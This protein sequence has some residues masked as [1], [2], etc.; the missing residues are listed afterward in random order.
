MRL[1][2]GGSPR[3]PGA[4]DGPAGGVVSHIAAQRQAAQPQEPLQVPP[5]SSGIPV[6]DAGQIGDRAAG[7]TGEGLDERP[8]L[9]GG[10]GRAPRVRLPG[11][12]PASAL[13]RC[14]ASRASSRQSLPSRCAS[15]MTPIKLGVP[16]VRAGMSSRTRAPRALRSGTIKVSNIIRFPALSSILTTRGS[17]QSRATTSGRRSAGHRR[18]V[19]AATKWDSEA[20]GCSTSQAT[21]SLW[22]RCQRE[23]T[24]LGDRPR[25]SAAPAQLIRGAIWSR[26]SNWMS[27]SSIHPA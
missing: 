4:G 9:V 25:T 21:P 13:A 22:S 8:L 20:L 11:R 14:T 16:P 12:I 10:N 1:F 23:A 17:W 18:S 6:D 26:L 7:G 24:A 5:H 27:S 3:K 15:P 2:A 19:K